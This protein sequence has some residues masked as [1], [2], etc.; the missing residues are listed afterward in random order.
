MSPETAVR[1]TLPTLNVCSRTFYF[2]G[3]KR[4][5]FEKLETAIEGIFWGR[6]VAVGS[7]NFDPIYH[8]W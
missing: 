5:V 7:R 4:G 3:T 2:C 1:E 8:I 6:V